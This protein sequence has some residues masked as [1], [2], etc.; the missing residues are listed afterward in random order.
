M[1]R[2]KM[3]PKIFIDDWS[4]DY[5]FDDR[6]KG[7]LPLPDHVQELATQ[8]RQ[9]ESSEP[10][11]KRIQE[12]DCEVIARNRTFVTLES[13][14]CE[15]EPGTIRASHANG[16]YTCASPQSLFQMNNLLFSPSDSDKIQT[17]LVRRV[18]N[19]TSDLAC[20]ERRGDVELCK[21]NSSCE[22]S[23]PWFAPMECKPKA[24]VCKGAECD[25][26]SQVDT[27]LILDIVLRI[28]YRQQRPTTS[29]SPKYV[30]AY[31]PL[32]ISDHYRRT[33]L[34]RINGLT[35][36]EKCA[37]YKNYT[38]KQ[39]LSDVLKAGMKSLTKIFLDQQDTI[40]PAELKKAL[41]SF[42]TR[43][44]KSYKQ[45]FELDDTQIE[46]LTIVLNLILAAASMTVPWWTYLM[47]F[48]S[49]HTLLREY[50]LQDNLS[51]Y[52]FVTSLHILKYRKREFLDTDPIFTGDIFPAH[53]F[54]GTD[55]QVL[56]QI[57]A[58]NEEAVLTQIFETLHLDNYF[59]KDTFRGFIINI[60]GLIMR[61]I[62][63]QLRAS[64]LG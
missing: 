9:N 27:L 53:I 61:K 35:V 26:C 51:G 25:D 2:L 52:L 62:S 6:F 29:A 18:Y 49:G 59:A 63:Q 38:H 3:P 41:S 45:R 1:Y 46:N 37:I 28:V 31:D 58:T 56:T 13:S 36:D 19:P 15:K 43:N 4:Y 12:S 42:L 57:Q 32:L 60:I 10:S 44:F 5:C 33:L 30:P 50:V 23:F 8:L 39:S 20:I 34:K 16:S 24:L 48:P 21:Q 40:V 64:R 11:A 22:V 55:I 54:N 7:K 17:M 14:A 47:L